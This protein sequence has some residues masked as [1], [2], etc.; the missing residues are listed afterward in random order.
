MPHASSTNR[1][2]KRMKLPSR[3]SSVTISIWHC[4]T[5]KMTLDQTMKLGRQL[6]VNILACP[7]CPHVTHPSRRDNG[8]PFR[9]DVPMPTKSAAPMVPAMANR[10]ICRALRRRWLCMAST[11]DMTACFSESSYPDPLPWRRSFPSGSATP[12][13]G[14]F[15]SIAPIAT[16]AMVVLHE[17][18]LDV[19]VQKR[20]R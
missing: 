7:D 5:E 12:T 9:N 4:A 10:E 13:R 1:P 6:A 20:K 2:A 3:G 15:L 18:V 11:T 16:S 8:P 17:V 14:S 19:Y